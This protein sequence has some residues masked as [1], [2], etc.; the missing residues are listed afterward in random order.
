M[1]D[2]EMMAVAYA[3]PKSER[4]GLFARLLMAW[5][6][7]P[8]PRRVEEPIRIHPFDRAYIIVD[9]DTRTAAVTYVGI[10][11]AAEVTMCSTN[12]CQLKGPSALG[13]DF[14]DACRNLIAL[15]QLYPFYRWMYDRL[16][17][18]YEQFGGAETANQLVAQDGRADAM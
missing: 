8:I 18:H 3:P 1:N 10:Y 14:E 17:P 13:D 6:D 11:S 15:L 12:S 5:R 16:G 9:V 4:P 7:E 2:D